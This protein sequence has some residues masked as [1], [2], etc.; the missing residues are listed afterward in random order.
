MKLMI[1][2]KA[3]GMVHNGQQVLSKCLLIIMVSSSVLLLVLVLL[4]LL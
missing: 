2:H 3:H 1:A 4:V